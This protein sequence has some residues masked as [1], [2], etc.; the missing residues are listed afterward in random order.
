[1]NYDEIEWNE[2]I[3]IS[4]DQWKELLTNEKLFKP[5][6]INLILR[7]YNKPEHMATATEIA[8]DEGK[9]YNSYNSAVGQLG[10]RI[11]KHLNIEAPK[12]KVDFN[13]YNYW[14]VMFL[15][16][17][18]KETG[19]FLWILRS[20]LKDAIDELIIEN[21]IT[22]IDTIKEGISIPEEI[23]EE[24]SKNLKEGAKC[25]ITVNA[26]ERNREARKIC[27]EYYRTLNNGKVK[28]EICGFDFHEFYGKIG[29]GKIHIHHIKP[30]HEIGN[31][32]KIDSV[33]DLIP[34]CPNCH[35]ILHSK[36]PAY[37][38]QQIKDILKNRL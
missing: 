26:Y 25:K 29:E 20:E 1:M 21:K 30:I 8:N 17:R 2:I 28:C 36:D 27:I 3:D 10:I 33:N 11:V 13:K 24:Q 15:G 16:T 35:L 19:H 34:V 7:I 22:N 9:Q 38:P 31:E 18:Q 6:N 37:T 23:S 12:Q 14:H 5:Y 32:Y 4:K